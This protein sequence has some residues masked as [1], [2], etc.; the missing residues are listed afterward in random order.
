LQ[1]LA[2]LQQLDVSG[3]EISSEGLQHLSGISSLQWLAIGIGD[4]KEP[5]IDQFQRFSNLRFLHVRRPTPRA[6][7][8]EKLSAALPK[9]KVSGR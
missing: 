1:E 8:L 3:N 9:V 4:V 7:E 6:D 2:H 5:T